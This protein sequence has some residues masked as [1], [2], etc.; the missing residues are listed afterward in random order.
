MKYNVGDRV[1]VVNS[2]LIGARVQNGDLGTII[3][4]HMVGDSTHFCV[5]FDRN[6]GGHD[7]NQV[8]GVRG[9]KGHCWWDYCTKDRDGYEL[10]DNTLVDN[11][12]DF[13]IVIT[14]DGKETIAR[15]YDGKN[16]VES[17]TAKC[18][19]DDT[20]DFKKGAEI[21]MR[22]LMGEDK[23]AEQK[24]PETN[25]DNKWRV[26]NRAPVAGDYIRIVNPMFSFDK[27]G[28]ILKIDGIDEKSD[29]PYVLEKNHK[30]REGASDYKWYYNKSIH[31]YEVVEPV[32][33]SDKE[34]KFVPHLFWEVTEWN[35]GN[36]GT[37]T[38][39]K[40][41]IGRPLSVGDT[42]ELYNRENEYKGEYPVC[43][44]NGNGFYIMSIAGSCDTKTG[45]THDWKIIKKRTFEE[46]KDGEKVYDIEYIKTERKS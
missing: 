12:N 28:D 5:Q 36:I 18:H 39:Y 43:Y 21:A 20:F 32:T 13:K 40:D 45:S 22:R 17:A 38:N 2:K 30:R 34:S 37:P 19:P 44:D 24:K 27:A 25:V 10:V 42:V 9:K 8:H 1:K 35:Y 23:P 26:V 14:T 33:E 46:V 16:V 6:I 11:T 7:G 4:S 3:G 31:D 29:C 41:A 15:L